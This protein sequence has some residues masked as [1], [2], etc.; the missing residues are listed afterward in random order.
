[1]R[2]HLC[3]LTALLLASGGVNAAEVFDVLEVNGHPGYIT[4]YQVSPD[5][6]VDKV[7]ML[8]SGFDTDNDDH[9]I[10]DLTTDYQPVID[11]L[12]P[13]GWDIVLFDY[14]RGDIDLK[15]NAD[16]LARFIEV[17]DS[18]AVP[19]YHLAL[20]GGSMGGIVVRTMF[21]QEYSGMGVD[22]FVS[23]DSP[24]HGVYL[25]SW[26]EG[27]ATLM[28]DQYVA[29]HQMHHGDALYNEH[30]GWL[31]S[32]ENDGYFKP[33]I[34][35][36]MATCAIALSNGE[37]QWQVNWGDEIIHNKWYGVSCIIYQE[38]LT[39]TYKPYHTVTLKD[40]WTTRRSIRWNRNI[41]SY[42]STATS[43]FDQKVPNPVDEHG[44]PEYAV[45]Q[46]I[47]FVLAHAP[48]N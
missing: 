15:Q 24:H 42:Y 17:V 40:D 2:I 36:P 37:S 4:A 1:M 30:Y 45:Q 41:Y 38:G 27:L 35:A 23:V 48:Q 25:S 47:N 31:Q 10:D 20:V 29:A 28:L 33:N 43:Y 44:A 14:V 3:I 11:L 18:V 34:I 22:T 12:G 32:V 9:P 6:I 8:V 5:G 13:Q 46:A 39:S 19:N 7:L 26:V 21:V 16:N